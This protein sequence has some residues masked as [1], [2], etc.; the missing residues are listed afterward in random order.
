MNL[1]SIFTSSNKI[2]KNII[3]VFNIYYLGNIIL[4]VGFI[5]FNF[6]YG[7]PLNC[8]AYEPFSNPLY[9]S[10]VEQAIHSSLSAIKNQGFS[11]IKT[12]YSQYYG[13]KIAEFAKLY[14]IKVVLGIWMEDN[15]F[16]EAEINSAVHSCKNL[17]NE[18]STFRAA[19][20]RNR[21]EAHE[22]LDRSL[23]DVRRMEAM[24]SQSKI[25]A[26]ASE[27]RAIE[28]SVRRARREW[29][30]ERKTEDDRKRDEIANLTIKILKFTLDY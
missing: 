29:E 28:V 8:I 21:R 19:E 13:F 17:E 20:D 16:I 4:I 30:A 3:F 6:I 14:G 1:L 7:V 15:S 9:P 23:S 25:A 10:K 5:N 12:Y 18:L 27:R 26:E 2:L 24:L 11:C 22:V